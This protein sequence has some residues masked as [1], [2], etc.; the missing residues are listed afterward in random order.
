MSNKFFGGFF[1]IVGVAV[2]VRFVVTY[3]ECIKY[4]KLVLTIYPGFRKFIMDSGWAIGLTIACLV[5]GIVL[6]IIK[7]KRGRME[8]KYSVKEN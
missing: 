4:L 3:H 5:C 2:M 1:I 7:E 8:S 6:M